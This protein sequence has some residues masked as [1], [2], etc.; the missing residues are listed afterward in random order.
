MVVKESKRFHGQGGGMGQ[1]LVHI[2]VIKPT[3]SRRYYIYLVMSRSSFS[4][5]CRVM[6]D[7]PWKLPQ[8][9]CMYAQNYYIILQCH[10]FTSYIRTY[11][12]ICINTHVFARTH[13][14]MHAHTRA[15]ARTHTYTRA[16]AI[17]Y[18]STK[19]I[20]ISK[21]CTKI[22]HD[23]AFFLSTAQYTYIFTSLCIRV[24]VQRH[25]LAL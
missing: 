1:K 23:L 11:E 18:T 24:L 19:R 16:R 22:F 5:F 8:G 15:R 10:I 20:F 14:H 7:K 2:C 17:M 4:N 9:R 21:G 3:L 13:A 25:T 6:P 12:I